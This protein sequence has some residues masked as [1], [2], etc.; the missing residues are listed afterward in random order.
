MASSGDGPSG[1]PGAPGGGIVSNTISTNKPAWEGSAALGLTATAGNSD[2][3][4]VTGNVRA[5][6]KT[7]VDEWALGADAAYGETKSVKNNESLHGYAEYRHLFT[8]RWY[9]YA[10]VDAL[11]DAIAD[12]TYRFTV[13]PGVGFYFIKE[14]E[15]TLSAEAGP[16]ILTEKLDD[17]YHTYPVIR[18]GQRL[19]HK[20]DGH[21]R[22]W[23]TLEI[24]PPVTRPREFLVNA[25]IGVET[26][27]TKVL[28]LQTYVQDNYANRPAPGFKDND[29][30][31]VSALAI[32][33]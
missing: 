10:K 11:H 7:T 13:S 23:E 29:V 19:E 30:K 28:S 33:F 4:L 21:A 15:T 25:E 26:P 27:I 6:R 8:P 20:F 14:K 18:F 17:E 5:H 1:P 2:S 16:A 3:A 24:L 32:K 31:V 12:V 22:L 9:G